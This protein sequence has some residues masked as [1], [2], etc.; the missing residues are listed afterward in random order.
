MAKPLVIVESNTKARTIQG[1]L[2]R[3]RYVV[4][5][6]I[7]HIRDLPRSAS[8]VPKSVTNKEVRRLGID[9]DDHFAPIYVIP[10]DKKKVVA[11]LKAALK[12]ASELYLAT[13]EDREG[14]AISWH[15]L[16]VLKPQ[17][18]VKRMVFHE[19]TSEAIADAI[20]N[21]RELDMKLVEAQEGRR[22]LDRLVGYEVSNVTFRRI[23]RGTSAGRVQSVATRLVVDRERARMAFRTATYWDLEGTF[24]ASD[25]GF[26]A[27]LVTLDGRRLASGRDFDANTGA[28]AAGADVALLGEDAAVALATR[29]DDQPFRVG[30]VEARTVTERPKAPFITS[31]LQQE[32]A[33]KLGFSAART[34]HVAQGLYERG[35]ITY[36]RTDSTSLAD[37][38]V[39]AARGQIGRMYGNEYLPDQPRTYRS[40]VK[41]AQEAHEAIR[42]AGDRMSTADDL[43]RELSGADERRLYDLIWKRT[44]ASQMADARI[45]RVAVRLA[46]T[47]T[48]GEEAVFQ[49]SGRTIEFPGYLRAYVEGAD[50]PDAELEDREALL[51]PLAEG[52]SVECTELHPSGHTTQPPAR[53]TEASLVKEL[54]ERGI[55]RPSTYA[56]VIDTIVN[57]RDY[58]WKKGTALVPSWTAF[59]KVQL[60]ERYFAHLIDYEFT[61]T[62]EEALDAIARGEGEAEK[63]L[64]SFYFGN[65]NVGLRDLVAEEHVAT[66]DM[67]DVNAVHVGRDAEGREL[68]VRVW[69]NGANIERGDDKA[70]IPADLPPDELTPERAEELLAQGAVGPRV[71]GND[72]ETGMPVLA[73]TGRFGPF[74]QLGDMQD[75]AVEKPKRASIFASMDAATITLDVAL[76]LLTLPRVVGHDADGVE[77]TAQNGRY[78]P[79]LRK[80]TD[81]RSLASEAQIFS[82]TLADAEVLFAQPKQQRG[83][84]AK[85]P[86]AE[87]GQHP[88]SGAA[89]R[90]LD[91]RY[92]P[93]ITD[94]TVNASVPRG[95]DPESLTLD[96]AVELLR[97]RAAR[98]PTA[99]RP[100]KRPAKRT[101]KKTVKKAAKRSAKKTVKKKST[102]K[103]SAAKKTATVSKT[104]KKVTG[105][106]TS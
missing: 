103:K 26:L 32:A 83:R 61:A 72:P 98:A 55:G 5:A 8:Q 78:G 92:G 97:E 41:N 10:E 1:F 80:G 51:P 100:A 76:A 45:R 82:V 4:K 71:L 29:L 106:A 73:L 35:L 25:A 87:L 38:A 102:A 49:A 96:H 84:A 7:G 37:Q 39:Q 2:G 64:H 22:V 44:V 58:A 93:Y 75:I 6:S 54:E 20:E 81:S 69:P 14:E 101:V 52:D 40:K 105:K 33:R 3:D 9:V 77:I 95:T 86:L 15:L 28:L 66:I 42:P 88:E 13:D 79:Y 11:E 74:V 46:A 57:K 19:I 68:I 48:A 85:P 47:S 17:V 65:G 12:D 90:V 24:R 31:T 53:Y 59:A 67:A 23:G 60:L 104:T 30:S 36:M 43:A 50:D 63:W 62:M 94:G 91:G 89:V 16:Q 34:M 99:N 21:W 18:P 27:S 56:S 70:P